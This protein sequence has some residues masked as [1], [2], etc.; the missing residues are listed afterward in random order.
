[1]KVTTKFGNKIP[2]VLALFSMAAA[3]LGMAF[4]HSQTNV[5]ICMALAGI[6]WASILALP[7]AMLSKYIKKGTEGSVMGIFNIFIA[8]PQVLVCTLLAWFISQCSFE[9]VEGLL[10]YHW[11][12][13]FIV[14][15]VMLI[16]SA[17][18]TMTIKEN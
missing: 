7:F 11:E 15:A 8:G 4:S 3:Y 6:G 9:A 14:G 18:A 17:F 1:M 10:N 2:H 13:A 16:L 12:Y 5:L